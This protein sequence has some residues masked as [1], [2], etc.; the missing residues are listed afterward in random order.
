MPNLIPSKLPEGLGAEGVLQKQ[1]AR[2]GDLGCA[3]AAGRPLGR[4]RQKNVF[5]LLQQ[6]ET[7][8]LWCRF[9]DQKGNSGILCKP[10]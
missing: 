8:V 5:Q 9:R 10:N 6:G 7:G 4:L 1:G 2:W 3:G